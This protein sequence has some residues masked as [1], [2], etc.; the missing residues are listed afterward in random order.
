MVY[1]DNYNWEILVGTDTT[2]GILR[3]ISSRK[4]IQTCQELLPRRKDESLPEASAEAVC[5]REKC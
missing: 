5:P 1:H 2:T 4:N 3:E